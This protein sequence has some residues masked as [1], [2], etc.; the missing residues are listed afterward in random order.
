MIWLGMD[1]PYWDKFVANRN[2]QK[3]WDFK[4]FTNLDVKGKGNVEVHKIDFEWFNKLLKDKLDIEPNIHL[5]NAPYHDPNRPFILQPSRHMCDYLPT[6]GYLFSDYLKG[7][8]WWGHSC[9]DLVY[10]DLDKWLN[11]DYLKDCDVFGIDPDAISGTFSIYRNTELV[12]SLFK[13]VPHWKEILGATGNDREF[14]EFFVA[15]AIRK[16]RDE[17]RVRFKSV[18]PQSY[19]I[20]YKLHQDGIKLFDD[21]KGE[22]IAMFHFNRGKIWPL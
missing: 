15:E 17:G 3:G 20:E 7:Y 8:E 6:F 16:A 22:E 19:G 2:L 5:V 18:I 10:G 1:I 4:V 13:E 11:E 9:F 14:D 12:N 21:L